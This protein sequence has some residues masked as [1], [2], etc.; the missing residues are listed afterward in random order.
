MVVYSGNCR[1]AAK[2]SFVLL[3]LV[4][5]FLSYSLSHGYPGV[6]VFALT[7][8]KCIPLSVVDLSE[9]LTSRLGV[10]VA[11][12]KNTVGNRPIR[13]LINKLAASP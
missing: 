8:A 9:G 4:H 10:S 12:S 5:G 13:T 6:V 11:F 3:I 1:Q 7:N 2:G